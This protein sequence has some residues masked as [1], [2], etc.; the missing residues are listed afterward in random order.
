MDLRTPMAAKHAE[1]RI[2]FQALVSVISS[3]DRGRSY[4]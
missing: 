1:Q 4:Q 2:F 3:S